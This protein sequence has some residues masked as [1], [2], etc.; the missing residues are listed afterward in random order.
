VIDVKDLNFYYPGG[1]HA[2]RGINLHVEKNEI[3]ALIGQNGS[4]KTTL[5]KHFNGLHKP[6]SGT[7]VVGGMETTSAKV[8]DLAKVVGFVFQNPDDQIFNNSVIKE[9]MF[10][11][12]L[13]T[14]GDVKTSRKMAEDALTLLGLEKYA[15]T[16]PHDLTL[17]ERKLVAI[18]SILAGDPEVVVLDEPTTAQDYL[19]VQT[20]KKLVLKLKNEGKTV[21]TVTHDMEFVA[22]TFERTVVLTQGQI[23][24]D[25]PTSE[26]FGQPE[27][28]K[29]AHV[30]PPEVTRI[31]LQVGLAGRVL[32]V[33]DFARECVGN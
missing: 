28:L 25:G 18:A 16:H 5:S 2:L 7:V 10:G 32:N 19:G 6:S 12:L 3:V 26:V 29:Q 11:A 15:D 24:L 20:L 33:D 13:R 27:V 22:E 23:M 9:A 4:G 14:G 8:A 30:E 17:S 1:V 21:L 31:A